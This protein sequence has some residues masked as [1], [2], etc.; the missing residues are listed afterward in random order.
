VKG[1]DGA[2]VP[3]QRSNGQEPV[4]PQKGR[5]GED[6]C[7][8]PPTAWAYRVKWEVEGNRWMRRF[9]RLPRVMR[10]SCRCRP[11]EYELLAIGGLH[12]IRRTERTN[13]GLVVQ[14]SPQATNRWV[15]ELWRL[16]MS[17]DA[18]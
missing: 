18:R 13:N 14:V 8:A 16:I 6:D 5:C 11:V 12:W 9:G 15:G 2:A 10:I 1:H 4:G 7:P 17:G 3:A